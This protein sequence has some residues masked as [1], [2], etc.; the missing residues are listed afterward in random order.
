MFSPTSVDIFSYFRLYS[1]P[2]LKTTDLDDNLELL[3]K[4]IKILVT[5]TSS[6]TEINMYVF[7]PECKANA[8]S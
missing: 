3:K 8:S 6:L 5:V 1:Y 4:T 7:P 2:K